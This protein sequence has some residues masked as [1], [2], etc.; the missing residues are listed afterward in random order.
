MLVTIVKL[1]CELID[2]CS[3]WN[4]FLWFRTA[5]MFAFLGWVRETHETWCSEVFLTDHLAHLFFFFYISFWSLFILFIFG[6]LYKWVGEKVFAQDGNP[7]VNMY[8]LS[9]SFKYSCLCWSVNI[10][11][12][13]G[14]SS[15]LRLGS[16]GAT[17]RKEW[18]V[19]LLESISF[20]FLR[21]K[22]HFSTYRFVYLLDTEH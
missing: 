12:T 14:C 6:C 4:S 3:W 11:Y 10:C 16:A 20:F 18:M 17:L 1:R 21:H 22:L 5:T 7:V 19:K 8:N 13:K 9:H 2:S 15:G